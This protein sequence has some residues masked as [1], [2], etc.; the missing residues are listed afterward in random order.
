MSEGA[1]GGPVGTCGECTQGAQGGQGAGE[2][3]ALRALRL[4]LG[5]A[6]AGAE[7]LVKEFGLCLPDE[8]LCEG[9]GWPTPRNPS[10]LGRPGWL[11]NL[12]LGRRRM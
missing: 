6:G 9:L 7:S 12:V 4:G 10:I 5:L 2:Q 1:N 11:V 3:G 8:E